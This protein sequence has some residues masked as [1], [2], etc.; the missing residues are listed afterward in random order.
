MYSGHNSEVS[1]D[2]TTLSR[3]TAYRTLSS[4]EHLS[5]AAMTGMYHSAREASYF[6]LSW[7][8]KHLALR[9]NMDD[10]FFPANISGQQPDRHPVSLAP[11]KALH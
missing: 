6:H 1:V 9:T 4:S 11:V 2:N 5:H 7:S 10:L 8:Q 3:T